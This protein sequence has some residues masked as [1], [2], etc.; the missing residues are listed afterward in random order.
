MRSRSG[1]GVRLDR[2]LF[3]VE[4]TIFTHQN[5]ITA[6]F[7]NQKEFPGH[8]WVRD[9]VYVAHSLWALYRAY[10]KSADFDEDLIKANELGLTW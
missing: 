8:A 4:Q 7:A 9:N 3:M 1:S 10:M 2:I 6:L 5:A